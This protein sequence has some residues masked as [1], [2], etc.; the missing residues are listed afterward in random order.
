ML[1]VDVDADLGIINYTLP[2]PATGPPDKSA[3]SGFHLLTTSGE[4]KEE[5]EA[6]INED[7][8]KVT[9]VYWPTHTTANVSW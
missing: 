8:I 7:R 6:E 5:E 4:C 2:P 3:I 1:I 9:V